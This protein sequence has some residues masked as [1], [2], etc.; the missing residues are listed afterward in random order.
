MSAVYS[1]Q[2]VGLAVGGGAERI[3]TDFF[4]VYV[5]DVAALQWN[6]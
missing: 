2:P 6:V 4:T 5:L 1:E 3:I